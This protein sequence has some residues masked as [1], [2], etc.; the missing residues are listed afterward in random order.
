MEC[1]CTQ[2]GTMMASYDGSSGAG[3]LVVSAVAVVWLWMR[4]DSDDDDAPRSMY[5]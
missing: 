2:N 1:V 5:N 4:A 3:W